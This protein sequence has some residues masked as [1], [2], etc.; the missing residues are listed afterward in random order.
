MLES[1]TTIVDGLHPFSEYQFRIR[2]VN[3]L[4]EGIPSDPS[5]MLFKFYLTLIGYISIV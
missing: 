4:G 5:S 1:K 3:S 2:A